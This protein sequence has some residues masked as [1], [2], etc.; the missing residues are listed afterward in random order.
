M[1]DID[2]QFRRGLITDDERYEQVVQIW[3]RTTQDIS[4]EMMEA[5]RPARA[6]RP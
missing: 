2:R 5:A 4:N 1:T 3:Q 6:A